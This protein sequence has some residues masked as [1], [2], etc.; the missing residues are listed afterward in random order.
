MGKA[1]G[2][3]RSSALGGTETAGM[4]IISSDTG[5]WTQA[6]H[7]ELFPDGHNNSCL[8]FLTACHMFR[9]E[10]VTVVLLILQLKKPSFRAEMTQ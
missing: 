9:L 1:Q 2:C 4:G 8:P 10:R 6:W 5:L 3:S 7:L